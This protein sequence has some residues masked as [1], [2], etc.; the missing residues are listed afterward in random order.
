MCYNSKSSTNSNIGSRSV[1]VRER[2]NEGREKGKRVGRRM[3]ENEEKNSSSLLFV[4]KFPLAQFLTIVPRSNFVP[5]LQTP[6]LEKLEKNWGESS[7]RVFFCGFLFDAGLCEWAERKNYISKRAVFF[8]FF[9]VETTA[10]S[11]KLRNAMLQVFF[12]F[13]DPLIGWSKRKERKKEKFATECK[14]VYYSNYYVLYL[15]I[16]I[17]WNVYF[18]YL[19]YSSLNISFEKRI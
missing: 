2:G 3:K 13:F 9:S 1:V 14:N 19:K 8:S 6:S 18:T 11:L 16:F 5:L 4:K 12:F 10:K 17:F 15:K 7:G